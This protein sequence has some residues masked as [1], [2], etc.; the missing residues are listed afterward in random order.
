MSSSAGAAAGSRSVGA[1]RAMEP[2]AGRASVDLLHHL[3]HGRPHPRRLVHAP[4][5]QL[6]E[7]PE[8]DGVRG[9]LDRRVE[10]CPQVVVVAVVRVDGQPDLAHA[11]EVGAGGGRGEAAGEDL[12]QVLL[13]LT[14]GDVAVVLGGDRG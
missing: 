11:M 13:G 7:P 2:E 5:R 1:L 8:P 6:H 14:V 3:A 4:H 9:V 12:K 10:E